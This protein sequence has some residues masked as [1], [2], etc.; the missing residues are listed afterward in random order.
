[1]LLRRHSEP[2][3]AYTVP[4]LPNTFSQPL[5]LNDSAAHRLPPVYILTVDS[6]RKP[7]AVN[8]RRCR[9]DNPPSI[10]PLPVHIREKRA[11][12]IVVVRGDFQTMSV[13]I[14]EIHRICLVVIGQL[15]LYPKLAEPP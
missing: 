13:R 11:R 14:G 8:H 4:Q 5:V 7:G 2:T 1:M 15:I 9:S 6:S 3:A 12:S 10:A